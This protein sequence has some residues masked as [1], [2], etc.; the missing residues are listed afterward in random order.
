MRG[1]MAEANRGEINISRAQRLQITQLFLYLK[2]ESPISQRHN[3][4]R[5]SPE[6]FTHKAGAVLAECGFDVGG[7]SEHVDEA[8][9]AV[10][11]RAGFHEVVDH[12]LPADLAV[13]VNEGRH[14]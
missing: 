4:A 1:G 8:H 12:L 14:R 6:V 9:L 3:K 5:V 10:E 2:R 7:L 13:S 11:Q